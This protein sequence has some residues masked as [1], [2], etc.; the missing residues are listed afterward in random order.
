MIE[1]AGEP[2][3]QSDFDVY[4]NGNTLI[5][6]GGDCSNLRTEPKVPFFLAVY[7]RGE[8]NLSVGRRQHGFDNLDFY[9]PQRV[10]Q[11]NERCIAIA[12]PLPEYDIARIHTGQYIQLPDGSFE[13]Q[14]EGDVRLMEATR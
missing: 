4:L 8:D 11:R 2:I 6:A 3:I 10:V 13:H 1:Q 7:P 12:P 14:W 5:Y 9:F